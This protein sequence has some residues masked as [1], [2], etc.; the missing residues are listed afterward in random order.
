MPPP[1]L[2]GELH[3]GHALMDTVEDILIRWHRMRGQ[4]TLWLPGVDHA[5]IAVHMLIE[6]QLA[7]EGLTRH[8]IGREKFLERIWDFVNTNRARIFDQHK[9]LGA[10]ADWSRERFTMDP[11]PERAVRTVFDELYKRGLIYRGNRLINW[12]PRCQT[13][14]PTSRSTT[15]KSRAF[16]GT[17]AIRLSTTQVPRPAST[18]RSRR[19]G[20]RRSSPTR[21]SPCIPTTS[22]IEHLI[23]RT[24]RACRS[25][26]AS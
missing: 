21:R 19:R 17:S 23:G 3:L 12:C 25:S 5:A 15:R 16:S 18:S 14:S 8:D 20:P 9:R 26:A 1:N 10:S 7:T 2:T 24:R 13:R 22:A 6:R 11:G 4:P